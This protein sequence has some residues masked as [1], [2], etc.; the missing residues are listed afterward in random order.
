MTRRKNKIRKTNKHNHTL[1]ARFYE[2]NKKN[3]KYG[4]QMHYGDQR[5]YDSINTSTTRNIIVPR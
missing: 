2:E 1:R 5:F 3:R 4:I